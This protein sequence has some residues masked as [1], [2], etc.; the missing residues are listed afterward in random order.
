VRISHDVLQQRVVERVHIGGPTVVREFG[1][2]SQH[3]SRRHSRP[4]LSTGAA[5]SKHASASNGAE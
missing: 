3:S 4:P 2:V 1:R 5:P